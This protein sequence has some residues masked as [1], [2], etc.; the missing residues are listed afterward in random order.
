MKFL[1]MVPLLLTGL[2]V[3]MAPAFL[4]VDRRQYGAEWL[5]LLVWAAMA[6][7]WLDGAAARRWNA[8]STAG[9]LLDPF[10]DA[11]F[12][13]SVF[14]VFARP[15]TSQGGGQFVFHMPLWGLGILI[16]REALVTF[17]V[18]PAAWAYGVVVAASWIGKAKTGLQFTL[19][20]LVLVPWV[21][22]HEHFLWLVLATAAFYSVLL[23]SV[24]SAA[25]YTVEVSGAVSQIR[26]SRREGT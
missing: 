1:R 6:T 19:M 17:V 23:F 26:R 11:L 16:A 9:K 21:A 4:I 5:L 22:E 24:G 25:K 18:R 3:L 14:Y 2:R 13:M 7:D 15:H 10:A 12:C 20:L 8:I